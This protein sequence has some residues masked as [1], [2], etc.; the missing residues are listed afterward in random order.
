M[1]PT[2][3][4]AAGEGRVVYI[5]GPANVVLQNL[6]LV[7]GTLGS[8]NAR[9]GAVR[10]DNASAVIS[11]CEVL[12]NTAAYG[13]GVAFTGAS[14]GRVVNT[15]LARNAADEGAALWTNASGQID[16]VHTT[17]AA[18]S[19]I[20]SSAVYATNGTVN[21]TNAIIANHAIGV[22]QDG[23]AT[24]HEDY[25][26]FSGVTTRTS[27]TVGGGAHSITGDSHFVAPTRDDYRLREESAAIDAGV[28]VGV[29]VDFHGDPRPVGTGFDIGYDEFTGSI[30]FNVYLPLVLRN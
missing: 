12:G 25:T 16:V 9:G 4:D 24:V 15:L 8:S 17:I 1:H 3:L 11:G 7:N 18:P 14:S 27:G 21:F 20:P 29:Y 19:S 10:V 26:L 2:T 13:G 22:V 5:T 30:F 6:R 28:D 23:S